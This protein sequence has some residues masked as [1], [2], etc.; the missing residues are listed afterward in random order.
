MFLG[1]NKRAMVA[2]YTQLYGKSLDIGEMS[3]DRVRSL[4]R[5]GVAC[6]QRLCRGCVTPCATGIIAG[7]RGLTEAGRPSAVG[8]GIPRGPRGLLLLAR[9]FVAA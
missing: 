3:A 9:P 5:D 1:C 8:H 4:P 7:N 2:E 6:Y